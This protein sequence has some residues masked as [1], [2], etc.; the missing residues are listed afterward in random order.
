MG[1]P[2]KIKELVDTDL[3]PLANNH[4][5]NGKCASSEIQ[6]NC[7]ISIVEI[8]LSCAL[9]SPAG[10]ITMRD[11]LHKLKSVKDNLLKA[12]P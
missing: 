8:G 11:A 10:R 6:G 7:L 12:S 2:D 4:C 1:F 3:F 5:Q 9:D